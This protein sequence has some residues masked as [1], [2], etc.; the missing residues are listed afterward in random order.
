MP[1]TA[2]THDAL[3]YRGY[4]VK[5]AQKKFADDEVGS[6]QIEVT[7]LYL[8]Y[9]DIFKYQGVNAAGSRYGSRY[10]GPGV[11]SLDWLQAC[12]EVS[13]IWID[14]RY[15]RWGSLSRGE[16]INVGI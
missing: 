1:Y 10:Q 9:P 12:P 14:G 6:P 13:A 5:E 8:Q 3:R 11:P 4:S 15:Q 7:A 16:Q 2:W